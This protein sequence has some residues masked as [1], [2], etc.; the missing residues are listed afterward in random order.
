M[1]PRKFTDYEIDRAREMR[2]NGIRWI[3]IETC[4]GKGITGACHYREKI[5]YVGYNED[6]ETQQA[7]SAWNGEG[8]R[9]SFIEGY[10][11]RAKRERVFK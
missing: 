3:V 4:V 8:D 2:A 6:I 7:M 1:M 11:S 10:K 5:G 9:Q